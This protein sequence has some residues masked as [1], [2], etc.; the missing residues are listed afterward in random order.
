MV[1]AVG[2]PIEVRARGPLD[3]GP[4]IAGE[5]REGLELGGVVRRF[6]QDALELCPVRP[7]GLA[8]RL[9]PGDE[10]CRQPALPPRA[11]RAWAT[12]LAR[13]RA[14]ASGS[15]ASRMG[16]PTTIQLAPA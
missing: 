6:D 8:H 2:E 1:H 11:P 12:S 15:T 9:E 4:V 16:R 10:A 3:A 14:A 7:D 5:A 13:A